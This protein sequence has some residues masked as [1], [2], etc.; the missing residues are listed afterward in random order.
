ML[1]CRARRLQREEVAPEFLAVGKVYTAFLTGSVK[2]GGR[3][4]QPKRQLK[5]H[6]QS[7]RVLAIK[8]QLKGDSAD[9]FR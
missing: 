7:F 2:G 5:S 9:G 1:Q 6:L 4:F 3:E 8:L